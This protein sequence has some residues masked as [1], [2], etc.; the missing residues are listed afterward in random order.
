[1]QPRSCLRDDY[2]AIFIDGLD[3]LGL[4]CCYRQIEQF[5]HYLELLTRWN[6]VYNLTAAKTPEELL[7]VHILDSLSLLHHLEGSRFIDVGTGA[8]FPGIPLSIM[9]PK[10]DFT[11]IDSNGKKTRFLFQVRNELSLDNVR[12]I[13]KRVEHYCP[14][15][16]YDM[17]IT[18]AYSKLPAMLESCAHLATKK[19][20]FV[21]MKGKVLHTE[22]QGIPDGY[23][24]VSLKKLTVPG[25][26]RDR[27][28]I[29]IKAQDL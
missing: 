5:L 23:D 14:E 9:L 19:T 13:N 20:I 18:R 7:R 6:E 27:H 21:A 10:N 28:I 26:D 29:K 24:I 15:Q 22:M 11:L 16:P 4:S 3:T 12:E 2:R 8:G 25:L 17:I 1:M